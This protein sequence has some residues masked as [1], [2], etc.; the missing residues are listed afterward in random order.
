[1][2]GRLEMDIDDCIAAYSDL[3]KTVFEK[4]SSHLPFRWTGNTKAQFDSTTLKE[5]IEK[6]ITCHNPS[7]I[8]LFNDGQIRGCRV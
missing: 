2:L 5:A 7:N 1:M 3:M 4:K 8:N 6:V